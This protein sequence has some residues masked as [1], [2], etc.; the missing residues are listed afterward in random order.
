MLDTSWSAPR[1]ARDRVA[2]RPPR[3]VAVGDDD[4]PAQADQVGA[5]VGVRVE[6]RS[7][8]RAPRAGS[9]VRPACRA[10]VAVTSVRSASRSSLIVPSSSLRHDV[11]GEA[12]GDDDV[13]RAG[14]QLAAL[15]VAARSRGRCVASRACAASVSSLPFSGSSPIESSRTSGRATLE[16]LLGEDRAHV[17]ELEQ[18]LGPCVGVGAA[19]RA[20][21]RARAASGSARRS[22][23]GARPGCG[24][25]RDEP[26][27]EHGAGVPGG[28]HGVR[29]SLADRAA[30][31]RR[32]SC[33]ASRARRRTACRPS[34]RAGW[35]DELEPA[36]CRGRRGPNRMGTTSSRGGLERAGDDLVGRTVAAEGV[37]GDADHGGLRGLEAERLDLAALVRPAGRADAVRPL[38]LVAASGTRSRAAPRC[39]AARD[40]C[41]G[42]P[43]TSSSWGRP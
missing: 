29:T 12:V 27:R 9:A 10:R 37:D 42:G 25:R 11:A 20:A 5:A 35:L 31:R 34:R 24:R 1:A 14:E 38:R 3:R 33:P 19:R 7:A 26:G 39:R 36:A 4:D 8:G 22:P 23:D 15:G 6:A 43:S 41:R 32:A 18:V 30:R 28:D 13:R 17:A 40:A 16:H 21:R 2:D